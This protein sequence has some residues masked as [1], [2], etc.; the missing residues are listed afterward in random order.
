M[1]AT[2]ASVASNKTNKSV[3]ADRVVLSPLSVSTS[4][5]ASLP[6]DLVVL[7]PFAVSTNIRV[8]APVTV[9]NRF[10]VVVSTRTRESDPVDLVVLRPFIA[11]E[12]VKVS[13]PV[14]V[15]VAGVKLEVMIAEAEVA[16]KIASQPALVPATTVFHSVETNRYSLLKAGIP[17]GV[18]VT[19]ETPAVA[20]V[21]AAVVP[22]T[23][24]AAVAMVS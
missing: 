1:V 23:I 11:S 18:H 21:N 6:V 2:V 9:A 22:V 3:P 12:R 7:N 17:V 15:T 8:S 13:E 19:V 14:T 5:S 4:V 10:P 20:L 24:P 16:P